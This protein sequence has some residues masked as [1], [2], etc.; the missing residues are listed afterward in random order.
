MYQYKAQTIQKNTKD[1]YRNRIKNQT[2]NIACM[3][4]NEKVRRKLHY[5]DRKQQK[6]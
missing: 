2:R 6:T 4:P 3:K 5:G 1:R